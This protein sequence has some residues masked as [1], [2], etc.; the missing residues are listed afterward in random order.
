MDLTRSVSMQLEGCDVRVNSVSSGE[1]PA[2]V[3]GEGLDL[4]TNQ[5]RWRGGGN[6]AD[7]AKIQVTPGER[8]VD[9]IARA[10]VFLA[11]DNATF[12][13]GHDLMVKDG[14]IGA[15]QWGRHQE[16]LRRIQQVFEGE[17]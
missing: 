1:D 4:A 5:R 7:L 9:D 3:V 12:V 11:S 14:V 16:I 13:N 8:M 2:G 15:W 6:K 17:P 10:V